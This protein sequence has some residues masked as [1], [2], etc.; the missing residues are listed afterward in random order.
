MFKEGDWVRISNEY[1]EMGQVV[2]MSQDYC[3]IKGWGPV[4]MQDVEL[5]QPQLGEWCWVKDESSNKPYLQKWKHQVVEWYEP[6][7]GTLPIFIK[8]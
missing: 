3:T 7:I 2:D 8:E 1:I 4:Y 5:W 6:F